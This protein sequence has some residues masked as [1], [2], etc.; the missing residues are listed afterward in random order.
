MLHKFK[1]MPF[2]KM[3]QILEVKQHKPGKLLCVCHLLTPAATHS[4]DPQQN[5]EGC[6]SHFQWVQTRIAVP[7]A[8]DLALCTDLFLFFV[9]FS[10]VFTLCSYSQVYYPVFWGQ[11]STNQQAPFTCL[12]CNK[13]KNPQTL[14]I[15]KIPLYKNSLRAR[16]WNNWLA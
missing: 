7:T 13:N 6:R 15:Q 8:W 2:C 1:G 10:L 11:S 4:A 5:N 16:Q 12:Q 14:Q 3:L 9:F